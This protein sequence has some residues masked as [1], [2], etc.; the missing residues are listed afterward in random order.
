MEKIKTE[1]FAHFIQD[2]VVEPTKQKIWL[3]GK[4]YPFILAKNGLVY[5]HNNAYLIATEESILSDG[6]FDMNIY[7]GIDTSLTNKAFLIE[8]RN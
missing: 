3:K 1:V 4:S 7:R 5:T 2:F 6:N 8:F